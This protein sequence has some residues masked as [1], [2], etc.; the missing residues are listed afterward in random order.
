[1]SYTISRTLAFLVALACLCGC[2]S[3]E[4]N[5]TDIEIVGRI[6]SS[7]DGLPIESVTVKLTEIGLFR[8]SIL[9]AT[10]SDD[11]GR[12][13]L[14]HSFTSG[15]CPEALLSLSVEAEGYQREVFQNAFRDPSVQSVRCQN[16]PQTFDV[17]LAWLGNPFRATTVNRLFLP[18]EI[19]NL[20]ATDSPPTPVDLESARIIQWSDSLEFS[21]V[22]SP[23][24]LDEQ[25]VPYSIADDGLVIDG[26]IRIRAT[27]TECEKATYIGSSIEL[28][29]ADIRTKKEYKIF[30]KGPNSTVTTRFQ[31]RE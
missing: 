15:R 31:Q 28:I 25:T 16:E 2:D 24:G 21:I 1:M 7:Y 5:V 3:F 10:E 8:G 13:S 22:T 29:C 20:V 6:T 4:E 18:A 30:F 26:G 12:Y 19:G 17:A 11:Q 9:A 23:G 14:E 27:D